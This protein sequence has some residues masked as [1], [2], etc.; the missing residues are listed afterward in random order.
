ML[1]SNSNYL[2]QADPYICGH[3][4]HASTSCGIKFSQFFKYAAQPGSDAC[5]LKDCIRTGICDQL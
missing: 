3:R 2:F 5:T 4:G 1:F